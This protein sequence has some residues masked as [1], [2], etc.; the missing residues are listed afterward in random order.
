MCI[1]N[2]RG[3]GI[4]GRVNLGWRFLAWV[5]LPFENFF[6]GGDGVGV[7]GELVRPQAEDAGKAQSVSA[8]VAG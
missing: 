8:L 7:C 5:L 1:Q 4:K 3:T 2:M 6:D